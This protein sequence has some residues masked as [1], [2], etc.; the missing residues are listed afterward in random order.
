ML[1]VNNL[2]NLISSCGI[3]VAP[4]VA[5]VHTIQMIFKS[6]F[7]EEEKIF[8]ALLESKA[9]AK[10][11]AEER[12]SPLATQLQRLEGRKME[13]TVWLMRRKDAP[14]ES[15]LKR[16]FKPGEIRADM[17]N[18]DEGLQENRGAYRPGDPQMPLI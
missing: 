16:K 6:S 10:E 14:R 8:F 3:K 1:M 12:V 17:T 15:Y 2:P 18:I 7:Q 11:A 13:K 5:K 9:Q 4:V